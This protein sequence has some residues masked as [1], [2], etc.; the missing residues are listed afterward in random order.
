MLFQ[1]RDGRLL[2]WSSLHRWQRP[3]DLSLH[4]SS[5]ATG[6]VMDSDDGGPH[7]GPIHEGYELPHV[8]L[9]LRPA[10]LYSVETS[11]YYGGPRG[12]AGRDTVS[13]V[14][15]W[16]LAMVGLSAG[17]SMKVRPACSQ[18]ESPSR[19][20]VS[21]SAALWCSS[22]QASLVR[23]PAAST[24]LPSNLSSPLHVFFELDQ[25]HSKSRSLSADRRLDDRRWLLRRI[26]GHW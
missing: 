7:C 8:F 19:L 16:T 11:G 18:G 9:R 22:R 17:Q 14:S 23:K 26:G 21:T 12:T 24:A 15:S 25:D 4:G 10:W 2:R 3:V 1:R 13:V 20:D 5:R 6:I